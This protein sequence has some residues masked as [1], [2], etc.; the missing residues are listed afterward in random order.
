MIESRDR[1]DPNNVRAYL[2]KAQYLSLSRRVDEAMAT[3]D[4]GLPVSPNLF[5]PRNTSDPAAA[6]N[7]RMPGSG[8][9]VCAGKKLAADGVIDRRPPRPL[10]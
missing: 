5:I 9:K 10:T 4:T 3:V 2:G 8:R 6:M 7:R 1:V